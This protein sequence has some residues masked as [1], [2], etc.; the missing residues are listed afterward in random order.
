[1]RQRAN[2]K[3]RAFPPRRSANTRLTPGQL[4]REPL[5]TTSSSGGGFW[6][7]LLGEE[8]AQTTRTAYPREEEW[9]GRRIAGGDTIL[10]VSVTDDSRIHQATTILDSHHP[11]GI[12]ESTE[13]DGSS[14][15]SVGVSR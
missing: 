11:I 13:E 6:A 10:I 5:E 2:C 1:M 8:G 3:M 7:W 15:S 12:E 9:Y 14:T 4:P